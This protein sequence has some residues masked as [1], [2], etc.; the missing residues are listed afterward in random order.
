MLVYVINKNGNPLMPCKPSKARKLLRDKKA[1]IVNYAPFTI[2]LQWDCEEYVQKVSVGIDRGSSYTGYCAISKDKVL[3]SG[4]IDHRLDI[5]DKLAARLC[6][7]KSRRSRLWYRK[8]RFL[9]RASSRRA[10]RL[11]PSIKAGVEEVFRVIRKLPIP[12][13][14]ITCED[15]LI[16]IAKLNDPSLKGSAYQK[17]NKLNENLRL[18]CLLRD[19]F[20]CYLCGNKRKHEK[21]EAHHIVPVSQNGKNSI[22]NLVTLCNKCHDDVHSEKL[23]LDLKGMGGIQDVVAQRTMIGKTYL[24]NLL[25]KY[26]TPNFYKLFGYETSHYRKELGLVKDH[27][28]DAFCIANYHARYNLTYERDNVYNVTFRAKQTRRRYHDKPQKGKG[29]V[30]YQVNESLEGFRKGDLVLVKGYVKQINSI[31]STGQL[32]FPRVKGEPTTSVPRK[33]KLLSKRP[34]LI[35]WGNR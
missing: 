3:I 35:F 30:E 25:K 20:T 14:E 33:C 6:N 10:G 34:T 13:F 18:A 1:K 9:N 11:P 31:Y 21:L 22:Y 32:A 29:R 24:Y 16:D 5:K 4:R 28:V 8:P 7:R 15:V 2:Q 26:I 12:I 23:K 17:S 27:D 19:N